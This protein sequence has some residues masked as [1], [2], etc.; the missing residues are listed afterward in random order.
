M[1][2]T[3]RARFLAEAGRIA[4]VRLTYLPPWVN[5]FRNPRQVWFLK[6]DER[7]VFYGGAAGGGKSA[8]LLM[9]A[10]QYADVPGYAAIL[11]RRTYADLALPGALM[12]MAADW[13]AASPVARWNATT[14]TW[15]FTSGATLSF[16]YLEHEEQKRRYASAEFQFVGFDEVV[17]FTESQYR[18]LFSRLRKPRHTHLGVSPDGIS[19][20]DVPLRMRCASNPGGRGHEWVEKRFVNPRTRAKNARYVPARLEDNPYLDTEEYEQSLAELPSTERRRLRSGDWSARES[21]GLIKSA[22]FRMVAKPPPFDVIVRSWDLAAT[23][24]AEGENADPDWTVGMLY[25]YSY[26]TGAF[27]IR[28]VVRRRVTAGKVDQLLKAVAVVDGRHV[29]IRIER[30]GGAS[31][32]IVADHF[33]RRVLVGYAV[34]EHTPASDKET[35][36]MIPA[37]AAENGLV[38]VV[39]AQWNEDFFA[40]VDS[41]PKGHDDQVD[42]WSGA[43]AYITDRGTPGS[44]ASPA[45]V[46]INR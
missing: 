43:H 4:D 41:F 24:E 15:H 7:E 29:P 21:G 13:L 45:G 37:A 36:A 38:Q 28:N 46:R 27:T 26:E 39:D 34:D 42:A 19:L 12:D 30:E 17:T 9:A 8:A 40:E 35:R 16:G 31:G 10:L 14:A 20:A 1:T 11:F 18:F 44:V 22:W 3:Q 25:S 32:K 33:A 6:R 5:P 23:E 2:P